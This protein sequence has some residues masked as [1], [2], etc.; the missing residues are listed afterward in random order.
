LKQTNQIGILH[1]SGENAFKIP[2][3]EHKIVV[4]PQWHKD[5]QQEEAQRKP[6]K[7]E[8][9]VLRTMSQSPMSRHV[10]NEELKRQHSTLAPS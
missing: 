1:T 9:M 6:R 2:P 7:P 8:T 10:V 4:K 3:K 5:D